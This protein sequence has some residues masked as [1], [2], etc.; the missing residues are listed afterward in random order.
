MPGER[1]E[2]RIGS[3]AVTCHADYAVQ[4]PETGDGAM[5]LV[6]ALHGWG[7]S[8]RGFVRRLAILADRGFL[9]AVPQAP[10][11]LYVSTE[12]KKVGFS[13]LTLYER[14][15]AVD[16][17]LD[18]MDLLIA[19]LRAD[20]VL[21]ESRIFLLG[22]S[23][24][25]SMAHRLAVSGR[26]PVAGLV[27]WAADLPPDVAEKLPGRDPYPVLLV[28]AGDDPMVPYAKSDEAAA[29]LAKHDFAVDRIAYTGGHIIAPEPLARVADW[30]TE[31]A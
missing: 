23:Q 18:Y 3:I 19:Q 20:Y 6:I 4:S 15:R 2:P 31:R 13:W 11:P 30:L 24:G 25:V 8:C 16:E 5:P 17:F 29:T 14:D 27:A 22:F 1:S 9:L 21:D 7:Q 28:H 26:I 12:P 10:H